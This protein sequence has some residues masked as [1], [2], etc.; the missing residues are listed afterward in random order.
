MEWSA[1]AILSLIATL[2]VGVV[3]VID[4]G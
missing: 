2:V 4:D 1:E 3:F